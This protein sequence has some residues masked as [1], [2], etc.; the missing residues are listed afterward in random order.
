M[1]EDMW[2]AFAD[3]VEFMQDHYP[4][5]RPSAKDIGAFERATGFTLPRSYCAFVKRFGPGRLGHDFILSAP[6]NPKNKKNVSLDVMV[7]EYREAYADPGSADDSDDP[8][9]VRRLVP[10]CDSKLQQWMIGWDPEEV[11][12][13]SG[14]EYAVYGVTRME[15]VIRVADSF[16]DFVEG[17]V[18]D[19]FPKS[20]FHKDGTP[21]DP[22]RE[23]QRC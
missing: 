3:S 14:P 10:F 8:D 18:F 7:A 20:T 15:Q 9:R 16:P 21:F 2:Q 4:I 22:L 12:D 1:A 19:R 5:R 17:Y 6:G 11:T 23:F 13:P